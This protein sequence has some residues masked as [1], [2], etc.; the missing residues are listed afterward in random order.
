MP[1]PS[2]ALLAAKIDCASSGNNTVVAAVTDK[3]IYVHRIWFLC[4]APV[5]VKVRDGAATDMTGPI[6]FDNTV[7][8]NL[9]YSSEPWF[10]TTAGNALIINLSAAIQTSGRVY[11]VAAE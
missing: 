1:D 9:E 8:M 5:D 2:Q 7:G 4:R 11:Y 3:R 10:T 6:P